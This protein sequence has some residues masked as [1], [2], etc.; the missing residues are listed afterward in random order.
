MLFWFVVSFFFTWFPYQVMK[1]LQEKEEGE[2]CT[3]R[4]GEQK[5]WD[6]CLCVILNLSSNS[7]HPVSSKHK[8]DLRKSYSNNWSI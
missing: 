6:E 3:V 2:L 1:S 8:F 4:Q 5:P 7:R